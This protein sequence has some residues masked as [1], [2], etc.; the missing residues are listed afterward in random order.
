MQPAVPETICEV[1]RERR[2]SRTVALRPNGFD[3]VYLQRLRSGDDETA[4][5]FDR[6][7]R[8]LL[9]AKVWGKFDRQREEDLVDDVMAA[10]IE[11]IMLGRLSDASCLPSYICGI[12]SNSIKRTLRTARPQSIYRRFDVDCIPD[13]AKTTELRLE[14]SERAEAVTTTLSSLSRR[15]R[16]VLVDLFYHELSRKEVCNKHGVTNDQLRLILFYAVRRFQ[17]KWAQMFNE[18]EQS[19]AMRTAKL[20]RCCPKLTS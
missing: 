12:L 16:E 3:E 8:R 20:S 5:H 2:S 4:R 7:F 14:E 9:R 11:N 6:H 10:A 1:R 17:K 13:G 15:D 18:P 19:T